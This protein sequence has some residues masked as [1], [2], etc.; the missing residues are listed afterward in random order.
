MVEAKKYK[1]YYDNSIDVTRKHTKNLLKNN[2]CFNCLY[3][4]LRYIPDEDLLYC[5]SC[6]IVV[7]QG[8]KDYTPPEDTN[9]SLL[10]DLNIIL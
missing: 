4:D 10:S 9:Y 3:P 1:I 6:G 5:H 2:K 8:F 7:K